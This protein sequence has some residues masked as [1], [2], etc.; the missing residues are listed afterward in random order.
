MLLVLNPSGIAGY[1]STA[2]ISEF[3]IMTRGVFST[4]AMGALVHAILKNRLFAVF[5]YIYI[6]LLD[7]Y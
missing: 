4:G 5:P 2:K 6:L 1:W 3:K 7:C